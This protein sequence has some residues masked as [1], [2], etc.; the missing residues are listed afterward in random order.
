MRCQTPSCEKKMKK[1]I[2]VFSLCFFMG[3]ILLA[4]SK[5]PVAVMFQVN[6]K[7]EYTKNGRKWKRVR[8]S[9]FLFAGY[10]IRTG[11][12]STAKVT[13][14]KSGKNLK[15]E[16]SSHFDVTKNGLQTRK[17]KLSVRESSGKLATGIMKRFTKSQTYTTVRRSLENQDR[18]VIDTARKI[19]VSSD[20]PYI[21]W[22]N[23]GKQYTFELKIG[24]QTQQVS[25]TT[26]MIVRV[27]VN[28]FT[29]TQPLYI[30]AL[31]NGRVIASLQ[32]YRSKGQIKDHTL[33]WID[34]ASKR[35]MQAE[36]E[37]IKRVYGENDFM[38]GSLFERQQMWVA[39]MDSYQAYL[40]SN[41][42]EIEMTPYLFRVYKK[43]KLQ[44]KYKKALFE[45]QQ[46]MKE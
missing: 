20:Y 30:S 31:E 9:K 46:A 18:A 19:K 37:D 28:P 25:A 16:P 14:Q 44:R 3:N 24:K 27:R 12:S 15:L 22:E 43:L 8:H 32:P 5:D 29:G 38:L 34:T 42:D 6:G 40:D 1:V 26:D 35:T 21:V 23:P 7:V 11:D 2:L 17:G 39:A 33:T 45:W 4:A 41:P 10:Q 13:I 36:I